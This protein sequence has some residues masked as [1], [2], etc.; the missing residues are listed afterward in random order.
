M[1]QI[2]K[3]YT[4]VSAYGLVVNEEKLLLCR[5][6]K[7][8]PRWVGQWTLPGGGID[9]GEHPEKAAVR[10]IMEE[11]G[12]NVEIATVANVNSI[13]D[14]SGEQNFHGIRIIYHT[15]YLGGDLRNEVNGT[16]DFCKWFSRDEISLLP[17]VDIAELGV[18]IVFN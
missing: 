10:E 7:Q 4:R 5:L 18:N 17:L 12:V 14:D 1:I 3:Q 11:T 16:T 6:S 8:L 15:N 2:K 9:F 13:H